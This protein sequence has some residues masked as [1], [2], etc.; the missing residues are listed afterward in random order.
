MIF[1]AMACGCGSAEPVAKPTLTTAQALGK[2]AFI[3]HCAICHAITPDTVLRGP[4]L[5]EIGVRGGQQVEGMSAEQYIERS[6]THPADHIAE[7]FDNLMP[8]TFA[9]T[10][11][12]EELDGLVAFLLTLTE[13][14]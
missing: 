1:L 8:S 13:T 7:G 11:S 6:I 3:N 2:E 4:S 10:L 12:G 14:P 5:F 9:K